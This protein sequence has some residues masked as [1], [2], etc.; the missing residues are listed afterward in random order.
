MHVAQQ[1]STNGKN[2]L[3]ERTFFTPLREVFLKNFMFMYEMYM[4]DCFLLICFTYNVKVVEIF[5]ITWFLV[6]KR[7]SVF[8]I[9]MCDDWWT[10]SCG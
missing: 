1:L 3:K 7:C 4:L 10:A 9:A 6:P 2:E 5:E 8:S